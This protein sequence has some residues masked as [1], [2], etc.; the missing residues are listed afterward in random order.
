MIRNLITKKQLYEGFKTTKRYFTDSNGEV[1]VE[2]IITLE[3]L[4]EVLGYP[5][6]IID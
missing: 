2:V 1:P 3:K 6:E 4:Q 5:R